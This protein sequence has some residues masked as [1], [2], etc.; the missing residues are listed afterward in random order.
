MRQFLIFFILIGALSSGAFA[1]TLHGTIYDLNLKKISN[2]FLRTWP[3]IFQELT[4]FLKR[5]GKDRATFFNHQIL[6]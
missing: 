2:Y 6:R 5:D 4:S 1:A 3:I